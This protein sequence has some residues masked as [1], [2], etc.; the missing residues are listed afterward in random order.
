M[1]V[2]K[3][4][5][6]GKWYFRVYVTDP[7]TNKRVQ[8]Q[9]NG[10]ELRR[11]ALQAEADFLGS[12]ENVTIVISDLNFNDMLDEFLAFENKRVKITTFTTYKQLIKSHIKEHFKDKK[13]RHINRLV[14]SD[15]YNYLDKLNV[16][17]RHKNK[18]LS[19]FKKIIDFINDQYAYRIKYI[20][21]F[22]PFK[23][24]LQ[25]QQKKRVVYNENHFNTFISYA[26]N[27]LERALFYTLFYTGVR[28]G[29]LRALTWNDI[30][31]IN[32]SISINKQVTSKVK[33]ERNLLTTPKSHSSIRDIHIPNLLI[34]QLKIW[35]NLRKQMPGFKMEWQ[36]FGDRGFITENRIR[37][38]SIRMSQA[39]KL[40]HI[41]LHEFRHSYTS[42]LYS[43]GIDPKIIQSQTGHSS[44]QITLDTYTHLETEKAKK[45]ISKIFN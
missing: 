3:N 36:V 27:D 30:D 9:R 40:P 26:A 19:L 6:T 33:G 16:T 21:T 42:L 43:K 25:E 17:A 4:E 13:I 24:T 12:Y 39:A 2:Y 22:P 37:R 1:A 45:E 38:M 31:F 41:K 18:I 35:L 29:E 8:R 23:T 44:V 10:F 34:E 28:I 5:K 14:L 32:N 15:W 7:L 20:N 11:D